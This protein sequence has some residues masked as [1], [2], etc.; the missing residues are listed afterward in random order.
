MEKQIQKVEKALKK[1][2]NGILD[3]IDWKYTNNGL[4]LELLTKR[5]K[6]LQKTRK[7]LVRLNEKNLLSFW[8]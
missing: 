8:A 7:K 1:V 3:C 2:E 5:E 6:V 4:I